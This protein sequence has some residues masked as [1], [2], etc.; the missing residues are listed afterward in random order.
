MDDK[1]EMKQV[2]AITTSS[3]KYTLCS[4]IVIKHY[5]SFHRMLERF[6]ARYLKSVNLTTK[7]PVLP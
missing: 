2:I 7:Y 4:G 5:P 6:N 1:K 3:Q